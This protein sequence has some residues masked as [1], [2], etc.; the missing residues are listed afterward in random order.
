M[1]EYDRWRWPGQCAG[2]DSAIPR[3]R[4]GEPWC[5]HQTPS[6]NSQRFSFLIMYSLYH[7]QIIRAS[8][9]NFL[10]GISIESCSRSNLWHQIPHQLCP[11]SLG[12]ALE[13]EP[14]RYNTPCIIHYVSTHELDDFPKHNRCIVQ[15]RR[16]WYAIAARTV[17][18]FSSS[19]LLVSSSDPD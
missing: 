17:F 12:D 2:V 15:D 4:S 8:K 18:P 16:F 3:C 6:A 5:C 19:L 9:N 11:A 1:I 10:C 13:T 7:H 14:A